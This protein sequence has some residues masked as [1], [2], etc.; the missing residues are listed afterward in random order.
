[1]ARS[2]FLCSL[3]VISA[4]EEEE[5]RRGGKKEVS[6]KNTTSKERVEKQERA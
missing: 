6:I 4:R 3:C 5:R 2:L 1:M